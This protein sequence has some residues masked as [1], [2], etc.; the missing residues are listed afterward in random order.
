MASVRLSQKLHLKRKRQGT[1]LLRL[2]KGSGGRVIE[3]SRF[4]AKNLVTPRHTLRT[5]NTIL[6]DVTYNL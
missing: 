1:P 4:A 5:I 6:A 2:Q 3:K